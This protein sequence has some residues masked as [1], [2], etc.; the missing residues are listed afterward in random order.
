V[1]TVAVNATSA[2][3][4]SVADDTMMRSLARCTRER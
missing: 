4:R 2:S 1:V 3:A